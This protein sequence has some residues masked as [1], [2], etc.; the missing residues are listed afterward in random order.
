MMKDD[1]FDLEKLRLSQEDV[2]AIRHGAAAAQA[3]GSRLHHRAAKL[4]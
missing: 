1:P 3:P 4:V 2:K